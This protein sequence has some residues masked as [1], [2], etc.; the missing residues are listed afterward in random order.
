MPD[1]SPLIRSLRTA[2]AAAP[3]DVPLR[4]HLAQLLLE[5]ARSDEAVA[6]VAVALQ[7]APDDA[8]ARELMAR[9]MGAPPPSPAQPLRPQ[10]GFDWKAAEEQVGDA[11]PP[12]FAETPVR[13]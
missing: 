5:A 9:A 3:A 4:L 13:A 7:H 8:Q 11:V 2:V 6:E 10:G 1:D 12:R